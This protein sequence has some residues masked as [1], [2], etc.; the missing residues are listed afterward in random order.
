MTAVS[1]KEITVLELSL[2][3]LGKK[4]E[5]WHDEGMT[6]GVLWDISPATTFVT[7]GSFASD[8]WATSLAV[9]G[10]ALNVN[11]WRGPVLPLT[12]KIYVFDS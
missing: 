12:T 6:R 10:V 2:N 5:V 4:V 7:D 1:S 9:R 3:D 11:G 8:T